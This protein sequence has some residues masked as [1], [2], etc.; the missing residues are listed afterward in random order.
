M[1]AQLLSHAPRQAGTPVRLQE[2]I[3][4]ARGRVHEACGPARHGF[5]AR[6]AGRMHGP[7]LWI[8]PDWG[9]ER[10]HA[11]GLHP[12]ADPARFLFVA[13][14]RAADLLWCA[15]EALRAG[16][17]PLVVADLPAVPDLTPVRRLQLA[18]E[19]GMEQGA[20]RGVVPLGLL[21][22]PGD[23][24]ARGVES[25]WHMTP[26]HAGPIRAWRLERRHARTA[27]PKTWHITQPVPP[28]GP[29]ASDWQ[30]AP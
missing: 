11:E 12:F 2:G 18:A 13:P 24:G 1:I 26:A 16:V 21:L 23:G 30:I 7:V 8:A 10:L 15:E 27:P 14:R 9:V 3:E 22:T 5:A 6:L 19:A 20:E 28:A 29:A 25:R 4:L 17:V